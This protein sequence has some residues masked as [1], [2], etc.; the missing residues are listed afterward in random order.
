MVGIIGSGYFGTAIANLLALNSNI[1]MY[2]HNGDLLESIKTKRISSG[3][4]LA[5]NISLTGDISE[6]AEKCEVI[7]LIVPTEYFKITLEKLCPSLKSKHIIIHGTKG[8]YIASS[9]G[10]NQ[11]TNSNITLNP[12]D[13]STMSDL[14]KNSFDT[15]YIGCISGPNLAS[16]LARGFP[17]ATVIASKSPKVLKVG[18]ELLQSDKL[19]VYQNQ[20]ILG[21]ELA[22]I[23]KNI[24]AIATG[25]IHGLGYGENTKS[26][27]I[28]RGIQEMATI[29]RVMKANINTF[30]GLSGVGDAIATSMSHSSRNHILG[31][32]IARGES[33][34]KILENTTDTFEGVQTTMVVKNLAIHF[35]LKLPVM[36]TVYN[37]LFGAAITSHEAMQS[38]M[39]SETLDDLMLSCPK[40]GL[41]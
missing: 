33:I 1:L 24:I 16:E 40:I 21:V 15:E 29:G 28:C 20:D 7:F 17:A 9:L 12:K 13:I 18:T 2:V 6:I 27:V 31:S 35:G 34:D 14:I 36:E 5:G 37:I 10:W 30:W 32:R 41:H 11:K 26:F 22:G 19:K 38:F 8:L 25:Y 39:R 3:Q 23:L 4:I